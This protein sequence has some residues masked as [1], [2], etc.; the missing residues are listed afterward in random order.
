MAAF[1]RNEERREAPP[2]ILPPVSRPAPSPSFWRATPEQQEAV[3]RFRT[4]A[5]LTFDGAAQ[6]RNET[7]PKRNG[8]TFSARSIKATLVLDPEQLVAFVPPTG[9]RVQIPIEAGGR[10]LSVSL[11]AK[12]LRKAIATA[13]ELGADNVAVILQ[14]KLEQNNTL[15]DAGL[16]VQPKGARP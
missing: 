6:Q 8:A 11:K 2:P 10:R 14:G 16:S 7:A 12:S 13:T 4:E 9:D 1:E 5:G 15:A 3:A